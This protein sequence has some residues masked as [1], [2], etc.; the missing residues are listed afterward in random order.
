M[1]EDQRRQK[2]HRHDRLFEAT[3]HEVRLR[4]LNAMHR[5][6]PITSSKSSAHAHGNNANALAVCPGP[7]RYPFHDIFNKQ[8]STQIESPLPLEYVH[9]H[10]NGTWL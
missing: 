7:T 8:R 9:E 6:V 3:V 10:Q 2:R 5:G 4:P 1:N